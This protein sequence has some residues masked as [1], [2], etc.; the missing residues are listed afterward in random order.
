M[1]TW[2]RI[3]S[4]NLIRDYLKAARRNVPLEDL[5]SRLDL[6]ANVHSVDWEIF[7]NGVRSDR[8]NT[9]DK[10][11]LILS[12]KA[13]GALSLGKNVVAIRYQTRGEA[14]Q[15]DLKLMQAFARPE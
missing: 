11:S 13:L 8:M 15:T 1:W 6:Q 7:I 12:D 14:P 10:F 4:R 9:G 2:L 5:W 3:T